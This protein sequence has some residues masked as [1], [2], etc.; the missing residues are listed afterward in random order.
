MNFELNPPWGEPSAGVSNFGGGLYH[1]STGSR[2]LY[3]ILDEEGLSARTRNFWQRSAPYPE[4]HKPVKADLKTTASV[5]KEP[6]AY[7]YLSSPRFAPFRA[8][9]LRG[10]VSAQTGTEDFNPDF[11]GGLETWFGKTANLPAAKLLVEGFSSGNEIPARKNDAWFSDSPPLPERKYRF[12]ALGLLFNMPP[13]SI[14][15]DWAYSETFAWGRDIYGNLGIR[16]IPFDHWSISLAADGAG[17]HF[18][19]RDGS[20][21]GPGFRI[22]GKTE[23]KGSRSSLLRIS[24][25]LRGP[26]LDERFNRSSAGFY[27]RLPAPGTART[28][29]AKTAHNS[30]AVFPVRLSIISFNADRNESDRKKIIDS[31]DGR[32]GFLLNLPPAPVFSPKAAPLG[33]SLTASI[34]GQSAAAETPSPYPIPQEPWRFDS[35]KTGSEFSWSPGFFQFKTH[36]AYTGYAQKEGRWDT[37]FSAGRRFKHGRLSLKAASPDFPEKWNWTIAWTTR[38]GSSE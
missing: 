33:I 30:G 11:S 13:V 8:V 23:R 16:V 28:G 17:S 12:N 19:C 9:A 35:F 34:K 38:L 5:S 29:A 14:S 6:E 3:G 7:L 24:A 10:F 22:A 27:Y 18:I 31:V 1:K 32:L 21:P 25:S 36:L 15:S 37:A 2:L 4:N 26:G 20:G